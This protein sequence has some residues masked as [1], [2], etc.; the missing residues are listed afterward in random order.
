MNRNGRAVLI[1][2]AGLVAALLVAVRSGAMPLGVRGE[3][4]WLRVPSGPAWSD[5]VLA[6]AGVTAYALFVAL[7]LRWLQARVSRGR[8]ACAV[9]GLLAMS[10]A[11][12]WVVPGGAPLGYGL[13]KWALVLHSPGSTGYYTVARGQIPDV[14]RFLAGYPEWIGKQDALHVGTHPPGLF[15]AQAVLLGS[16]KSHPEV[17][18]RV[19]AHLPA[20][21]EQGFRIVGQYDRLAAADRAALALMGALTWLACAA[22]VVPL[23]FLARASLPAPAAWTA[24]ALWPLVPS[25]IL[26]Q[27]V[28]DTAFPLLATT[29]LALAVHAGRSGPGSRTGMVLA[30]AAGA[31]LAAGMEFTLAFL[32]VGLIAG[33]VLATAANQS[34]P[35]RLALIAATGAGFLGLTLLIWAIIGANPFV[36]WWWNQKNHARFY[37]EYHR[38]YRAWV[39]G[40]PIEL[41]VA[42]GVPATVWGLAGLGPGSF[43]QV[44]RV[45]WATL[46][47]LA[48]LTLS[49]RNLSEVA[50]LWLPLMPPLL[51]ASGLGLTRLGG[52]PITLGATVLLL[53]IETLALQATIQVV[54]P[55]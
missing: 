5:V 16:M 41:A 54:Y 50:R 46:G 23:Y 8:E 1:A 6:F 15:V 17:A 22:T 10:V 9:L 53:G 28:A 47:V 42:L 29:A 2:Q 13:T 33:L 43:R 27:P 51:T 21:V 34:L 49:G 7:G 37:V 36:I 32:P 25:A 44:P 12:Q 4:E 35:R 55:I 3:W 31:A 19:V 45:V 14:R 38:S 39:L 24:A 48:A 26:F 40:N 20:S 18:R 11:V 30:V 52:G